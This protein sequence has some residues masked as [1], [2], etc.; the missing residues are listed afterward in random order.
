MKGSYIFR[1]VVFIAIMVIPVLNINLKSEQVSDIDNRKLT[2]ASEILEND[3]TTTFESYLN[4]RIGFRTEMINIY[5]RSMDKIFNYMVHPSYQ[6]G[7]DGYVYSYLAREGFDKRF[8]DIYSDFI[9]D[10]QNYCKARGIEFLYALEP[11]KITVYDEHLPTGTKYENFNINY[12]LQQ[13]EEKNVNHIYTGEALI[14]NKE[15]YQ[16]YD[17]KFD[18]N[19]WNETGAIV[20]MNA[21]LEKLNEQNPLIDKFDFSKYEVGTR[22]NTTLPVSYFPINEETYIYD[23]LDT[24]VKEI[25]I[26]RDRIKISEQHG[27]FS[28]YINEANKD[29]PRVLV[30]AGSY[31]NGKEKFLTP[32]FSEYIKVHNYFNVLDYDYY[33]NLFNPDIV[34]FESTEYTHTDTYFPTDQMEKATYNKYLPSYTDLKKTQYTEVDGVA[35]VDENGVV[36]DFKIPVTNNETLYSYVKVGNRILDARTI[37]TDGKQF[38]TF[39]VS[40]YELKNINEINIYTV[41]KDEKQYSEMKFRFIIS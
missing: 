21:I 6:Y 39:S 10:M 5:T 29:A 33:I 30:F 18:A 41:A 17:I 24:S 36:V 4:D 35:E 31:F 15:E 12:L 7:K 20:A 9:L 1:I 16:L 26:F 38:I 23:L 32:S 40:S 22:L 28:H 27:L 2:E 13:L 14:A 25:D 8:Q 11:S 34:I 37:E 19:H 3:F